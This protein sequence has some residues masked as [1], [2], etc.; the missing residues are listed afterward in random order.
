MTGR[1]VPV[2]CSSTPYNA[3]TRDEPHNVRR[4]NTREFFH[5]ERTAPCKAQFP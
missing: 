3:D 4:P 2:A 5:L 1:T